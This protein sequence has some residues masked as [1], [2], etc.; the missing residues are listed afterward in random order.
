[1]LEN[2]EGIDEIDL[3]HNSFTKQFYTFNNHFKVI[4]V[5][6]LETF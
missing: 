6:K 3:Y 1:M 5:I 4:K 2:C